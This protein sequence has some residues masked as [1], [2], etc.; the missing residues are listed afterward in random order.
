MSN[1]DNAKNKYYLHNKEIIALIITLNYKIKNSFIIT[2]W[3][4]NINWLN[5]WE[6]HINNIFI[7]NNINTFPYL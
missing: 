5:N 4:N 3:Y 1:N 7:N 2:F 6:H